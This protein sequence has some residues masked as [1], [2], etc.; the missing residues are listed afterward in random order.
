M[1][2]KMTKYSFIMLSSQTEGF[3][4][5]L[6]DL[7][8]VDITRSEKPVDKA[9]SQLLEWMKD[10][11]RTISALKGT[12]YSKET[13]FEAIRKACESTS[14]PDDPISFYHTQIDALAS[15]SSE[16]SS[17][18]S[19]IRIRKPWGE[20]DK[21]ELAG[22]QTL[23]YKLHYYCVPAKRFDPEWKTQFALQ[24]ISSDDRKIW[25]VTVSAPGEEYHFPI[26]ETAAP[27]GPVSE[28]EAHLKE[29]E[30]EVISV[31]GRILKAA[32]SVPKLEKEYA[33]KSASLDLYLAQAATQNAAEDRIS[34]LTGFAPTEDE[35]KLKEAFDKMDV[36]YIAESAAAEDNPPIKLKNNKFSK[37][38]EV[39]TGMY[40]MPVYNEFDPTPVLA[41]FFLL[42]FGICMGDGGYG[43]IL[44]LFGIGVTKKWI[45]ID[46]FK[47]LGPLITVLGAGTFL[48][49][50]VL[51]TA[52]G[53]DLYTASWYP[54]ALKKFMITDHNF[55]LGFPVQMIL[56]L[57]IG[58]FH[59]C[60]AMV[61][62]AVLYTKRFG[63][64]ATV[65][66]WGWLVLILG[67]ITIAAGAMTSLMPAAAV[68][69][70]VIAVGAVSALG[71]FI[72]NTPGRNPLVNIG[73]GLWDT[74]NMVT[75][76]LGDVL[77]YI[78]LYALGL[79]GGMLGNAFNILGSMVLGTPADATWQWLPFL[80]IIL[81]GHTL[82][83][84]MSCLGA[85]VHPL[86]L[87]FVEYF[88]NSGYEGKGL[89]YRPLKSAE[90]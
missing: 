40:G 17:A 51:G 34:I 78:R 25:F 44:I 39:L 2:E 69:W 1:I 46:M 88:K 80:I 33:C 18:R 7:G 87:T 52:F 21:T 60:L 68:K 56:A 32:S 73:S 89:F 77:S 22:L 31:K 24:E 81:L 28:A 15:L 74:Y 35:A 57:G 62:K 8:I 64:K 54:D 90:K 82:N 76:L 55:D 53:M 63:F 84:L 12:D 23:G 14:A 70:A 72:F 71:I 26:Q 66:I 61:T 4:S 37:L 38:F 58:V 50:M 45:N 75:G 47:N 16:I 85:F 42:F 30:N 19:E 11:S 6:Q 5:G 29:L 86:R 48:V 10:C 3:L 83:I 27:A 9:S 13:D 79:A 67:G 59:I 20:F 41:V 43:L 36:Y 65:S 49:G